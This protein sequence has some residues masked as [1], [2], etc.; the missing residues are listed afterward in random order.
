MQFAILISVLVALLLGAFLMLTHAQSFFR[1]KSIELVQA[2][3][4]SNTQLFESLNNNSEVSDTIVS[5]S[6]S[7]TT[8]QI[9]NYHGAWSKQYSETEIHHR[10]AKR[11]AFTGS[12]RAER[13]PN[14]YLVNTNSP[15]VVVGDTRLEGNS[16]LPKQG[17]KAGNISGNYYQGNSLYYGRAI[18]SKALLPELEAG[19]IKY[20]EEITRGSLIEKAESISLNSEL[21]NSFLRPVQIVYDTDPIFLENQKIVGNI[22]IQSK[23]SIVIGPGSQLTDIL[24]IAPKIEVKNG[25]KG[26][27]Q[28]I[29]TK[30]IKIGTRCYLSYPSSIVLLDQNVTSNTTQN[31]SGQQTASDFTIDE[32]TIIEGSVVYLNKKQATQD[33]IKTHLAIKP[34]VEIVGETYC[35]GNVDF[36]GTIWGSLYTRQCIA[37]QSGSIYLNHIYNGK[38]LVNPVRDYAG[39]PLVNSKNNVAKWLY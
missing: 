12:K 35:Q 14:L 36:Q 30:N 26:N 27:F 20:L 5:T 19:W 7:K 2:F 15:L 37:R 13:T 25:V 8:K 11:V 39:I 18:E 24:L 6:G 33:R 4:Q 23:T 31:N 9:T 32:R 10:K 3:E 16:Y 34:N 21:S 17:V 28:V 22:V 38:I 1:I 29:A